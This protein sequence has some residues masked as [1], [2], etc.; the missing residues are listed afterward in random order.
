M[1]SDYS[2]YTPEYISGTMSLRKPQQRS[3]EIPDD[4]FQSVS[5]RKNMILKAACAAIHALYP[6]FTDFERDFPS[7]AFAL[8]F[9]V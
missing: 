5:F 4:L 7:L 1:R 8:A 3:L 6:T 2:F 9:S